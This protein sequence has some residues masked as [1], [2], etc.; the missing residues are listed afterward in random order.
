[1]VSPENL[2][3]TLSL[4]LNL[5]LIDLKRHT[6]QPDALRLIPEEMA[7]KHKLI[8]LGI[9]DGALGVVMDDPADIQVIEELTARAGMPVRPMVGVKADIEAAIDL[10]WVDPLSTGL[11]HRGDR[12][13]DLFTLGVTGSSYPKF[14][15]ILGGSQGE[16]PR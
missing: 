16:R 1:M 4:H 9:I 3:M 10:G 12:T 14:L 15:P 8:P 5:P 6:V 11:E 2:A 7:R 13:S